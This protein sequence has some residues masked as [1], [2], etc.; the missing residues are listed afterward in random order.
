VTEQLA[1]TDADQR[2]HDAKFRCIALGVLPVKGVHQRA[3][4][5]GPKQPFVVCLPLS[6]QPAEQLSIVQSAERLAGCYRSRERESDPR[7]ATGELHDANPVAAVEMRRQ[8][9]QD[10]LQHRARRWSK[11]EHVG[12]LRRILVGDVVLDGQQA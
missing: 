5:G 3:S 8:T 12:G 9:C 6:E 2:A 7:V 10:R 4:L 11:F 1:P